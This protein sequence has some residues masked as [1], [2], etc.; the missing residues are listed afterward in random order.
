[1]FTEKNE[2]FE[3]PRSIDVEL[4]PGMNFMQCGQWGIMNSITAKG[5]FVALSSWALVAT[6]ST[7]DMFRFAERA[8]NTF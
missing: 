2:T 1:M 7:R 3:N 6:D 4:N 5:S 8:E